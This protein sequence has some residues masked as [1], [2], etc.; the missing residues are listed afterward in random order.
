VWHYHSQSEQSFYGDGGNLL[1]MLHESTNSA[2][3]LALI[4]NG[5]RHHNSYGVNTGEFIHKRI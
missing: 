3:F 1:L 2:S 5:E 4:C